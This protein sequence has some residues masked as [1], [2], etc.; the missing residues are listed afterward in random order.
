MDIQKVSKSVDLLLIEDNP[1]DLLLT[2]RML[3]KA[4]HTSFHISYADSLAK[5]IERAAQSALV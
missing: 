1:S 5:G 2:K 4:E 3:E